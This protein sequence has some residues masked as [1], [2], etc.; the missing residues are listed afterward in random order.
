VT[1]LDLIFNYC[2]YL[3][4][5]LI[6]LICMM[7]LLNFHLPSN[8]DSS[9]AFMFFRYFILFS[10]MPPVYIIIGAYYCWVVDLRLII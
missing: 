6:H 5:L 8:G 1:S 3:I 10:W 9:T 2:E 4:V 7:A